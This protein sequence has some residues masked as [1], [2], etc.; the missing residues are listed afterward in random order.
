[1]TEQY[2]T[3]PATDRPIKVGGRV[4]KS[5]QKHGLVDSALVIDKVEST[6]NMHDDESTDDLETCLDRCLNEDDEEEDEEEDDDD[7]SYY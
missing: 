5:L 7:V 4:W 6:D 3:N 2:V 1:M